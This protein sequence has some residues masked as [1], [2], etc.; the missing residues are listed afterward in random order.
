MQYR[1]GS[2][3]HR[4]KNVFNPSQESASKQRGIEIKY[5]TLGT[6]IKPSHSALDIGAS[7]GVSRA[8]LG[9]Q[10]THEEQKLRRT[11]VGGD[12]YDEHVGSQANC[13]SLAS[14][15]KSTL[16]LRVTKPAAL[17]NNMG[18]K[19]QKG[20][21]MQN[22]DLQ[23]PNQHLSRAA[24]HVKQYYQQKSALVGQDAGGGMDDQRSKRPQH[25][26]HPWLQSVG[27]KQP[28]ARGNFKAIKKN[29]VLLGS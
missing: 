12:S 9:L 19:Y 15:S 28:G 10:S 3:V 26:Q 5:G 16:S 11:L 8:R 6:S 27:S 21:M 14:R 13:Q 23:H 18:K 2:S 25:H 1:H 4:I 24:T 17:T 7:G 20:E 22:F 29:A